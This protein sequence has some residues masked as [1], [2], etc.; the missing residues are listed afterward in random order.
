MSLAKQA[1]WLLFVKSD[2]QA[3]LFC[4][5]LS[6]HTNSLYGNAGSNYSVSEAW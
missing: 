4:P 3:K 2:M 5:F 6:V 1:S